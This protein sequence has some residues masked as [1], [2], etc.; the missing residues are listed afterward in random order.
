M[1]IG[2]TTVESREQAETL[3]AGLVQERLAACVQVDG[4]IRSFYR[5]DGQ[6]QSG[7]EFRLIIKFMGERQVELEA[8]LFSRHPYENPQWLAVRAELVAEKYLS[9][10]HVNSSPLPL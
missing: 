4:P 6:V 5:W 3:A 9:W 10:A 7:E 8:W 2:W 1:L